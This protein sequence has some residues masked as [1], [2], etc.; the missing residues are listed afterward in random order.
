MMI[1]KRVSAHNRWLSKRTDALVPCA[2][3]LA[4]AKAAEVFFVISKQNAEY[5]FNYLNFNNSLNFKQQVS[6]VRFY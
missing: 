5:C 6:L 4:R 1:T 3:L 2:I